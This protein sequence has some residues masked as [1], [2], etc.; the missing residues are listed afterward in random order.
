MIHQTNY[1]Q[2]QQW[3]DALVH[4]LPSLYIPEQDI[5]LSY[6]RPIVQIFELPKPST[7]TAQGMLSNVRFEEKDLIF[8]VKTGPRIKKITCNYG[9]VMSPE[10]DNSAEQKVPSNRGRRPKQKKVSMRKNQ[11]NGKYFSSQITFW[12]LSE[13]IP[14]KYYKIKVFRTG[15]VEAPGGLDPSMDDIRSALGVVVEEMSECL[16]CDVSVLELYSIMRNYKFETIDKSIRINVSELYNILVRLHL[17]KDETA[18]GISEIKYNIE[19]Y[20]G[21]I[22]KFATPINRNP[23]KQTTIKMFQ[24]GKVNIDGAISEEGAFHYY[25]WVNDLYSKYS[26]SIIYTP[27]PNN[28]DSDSE[29]SG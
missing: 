10:F 2:D 22:I 6:L 23:R 11:G 9:E 18:R 21:L 14:S 16:G 20:P 13:T 26:D 5:V 4:T 12:V 24:S 8:A 15:P 7:L 17:A 29:S 1:V 27:A 3:Y 25:C 28:N 19:R